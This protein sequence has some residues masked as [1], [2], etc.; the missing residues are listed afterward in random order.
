[1]SRL[2]REWA[3]LYGGSPGHACVLELARPAAWAPLAVVW[4]G[5][6][7]DFGWPA[8]GIAVNGEDALQLWFSFADPVSPSEALA[9]LHGLCARYL[10]SVPAHRLGLIAEAV[11]PVVPREVRPGAQWAAF[12]AADLAP[13]FEET[14][15]LDLP[16]PPEGQAE[17]LAALRSISPEAMALARTQLQPA[18]DT[19]QT[20]EPADPLPGSAD[21]PAP[22]WRLHTAPQG[23]SS[24]AV[25]AAE[26][27]LLQVMHN[28]ALPWPI[29]LKAARTL[30]G[31]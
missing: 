29:R 22:G 1:M 25:Q 4:Q 7:A 20:P 17:L 5:V 8:P 19:P 13:V 30:L 11:P 26:T 23:V 16:P 9:Q 14:P 2:A 15:W 10:P 12:V 18:G 21:A 6:Q 27:F 24:D 3:R 31:H 28:E